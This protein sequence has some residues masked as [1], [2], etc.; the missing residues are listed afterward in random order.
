VAV[1]TNIT[2]FNRLLDAKKALL[3]QNRR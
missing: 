2:A 3:E 1:L